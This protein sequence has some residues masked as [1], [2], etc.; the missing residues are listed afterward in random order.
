MPTSTIPYDPSL[1]L[2]M[3]V[4]PKKIQVLENIATLQAPVDAARDHVN[5]LLRQKLSLDMTS[6]ELISLG[7][8]PD[9]L[10]DFQTTLDEL[11]GDI[12]GAAVDL[13]KAVV[14]AEKAI[15]AAKVDAGQ[16]QIGM[17]LQSPVDFTA[18]QLAS[19]PLSSDSMNMDVQYFRYEDNKQ[20]FNSTANSISTFVGVKVS[21]FLGSAFGAQAATSANDSIQRTNEAHDLVGTLV[22]CANCTSRQ[23]QIFSPLVLDVDAAI[24]TFNQQHP[25]AKLPVEAPQAMK[26]VALTNQDTDGDKTLPVLIGASYG[27]SFVGFV[28]FSQVEDTTS[29]QQSE[30]MAVQARAQA[31]D[32]LFLEN[33]Q[34]SWGLDAQSA[35]S[36]KN[37]LSTSNI[38]SHCSVITMGLIPSIKS[39]QVK[40]TVKMLKT[41]PQQDMASL[42]AL[43]NATNTNSSSIA[44]DAAATRKAQGMAKMNAD[45]VNAAVAAVGTLDSDANQVIN[46]NSLQT[47]LDDYVAKAS[48]GKTGVPINFYLKYV[49]KRDIAEAWMQKYYPAMLHE[50]DPSTDSSGNQPTS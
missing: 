26:T 47:A 7:A 24:D 49:N 38:Q 45:F 22:I 33:I 10:K 14:A 35:S 48:D 5:A 6:R 12:Q 46:L 31:E 1:V 4:D 40:A 17:Q 34:G 3:I 30:S 16:Q 36:I 20:S 29:S 9:Q 19:L 25:D 27:S 11:M 18:S 44:A 41:D 8:T 37:M 43:Q 42:A 28:H 21:S 2:G 13:A 15:V 23:A 50:P 32:D 39:N